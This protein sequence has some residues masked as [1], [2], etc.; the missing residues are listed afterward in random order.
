M[1]VV[2]PRYAASVSWGVRQIVG[3]ATTRDLLNR[4]YLGLASR[5][6]GR[7][8][9][10]TATV[11]GE[12]EHRFDDG[13]WRVEFAGKQIRFPLT[14]A[15]SWLD[16][17][18]CVAAL[19][20]EPAL[21]ETYRHLCLGAAPP[22]MFVDIGAN[23]GN[24]SLL[25]LT[26]GAKVITFEPNNTCHPYFLEICSLNGVSPRLEP[27]ALGAEPGFVELSYPPRQ[28][29]LGSTHSATVDGLAQR[30]GLVTQRVEAKC[31]DDYYADLSVER[32]L[33]KIDAEGSEAG[34]LRGAARVLR[35][36]R[37]PVLFESWTGARSLRE[38]LLSLFR[39]MGYAI[40]GLPLTRQQVTFLDDEGFL[41]SEDSDFI[42]VAIERAREPVSADTLFSVEPRNMRPVAL[43]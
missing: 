43:S 31:L 27:V 21:K 18:S 38:E 10:A 6:Q 15:R 8:Y 22:S 4:I 37:P 26:V 39:E 40:G 36:L 5:A 19:G 30:S 29:W 3:R 42:A 17:E 41:A 35:E 33:I 23:Y 28:T 12:G 32:A 16:W 1:A 2:R 20:H 34:I 25:F 24:H 11:F 7:F 13:L 14:A 9:R